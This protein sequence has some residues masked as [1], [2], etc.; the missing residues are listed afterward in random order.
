MDTFS[1]LCRVH[2]ITS[3]EGK[4]L[5]FNNMLTSASL[6]I[7]VCSAKHNLLSIS[8]CHSMEK[9]FFLTFSHILTSDNSFKN[10]KF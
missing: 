8:S 2:S 4:E 9:E 3:L 5:S 1:S 7:D 10:D 6:E